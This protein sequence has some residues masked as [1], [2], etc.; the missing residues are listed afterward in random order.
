MKTKFLLAFFLAGAAISAASANTLVYDPYNVSGPG[1]YT[2]GTSLSNPVNNNQPAAEGAWTGPV[3]GFTTYFVS[4]EGLTYSGLATSGGSLASTPLGTNTRAFSSTNITDTLYYSFLV[5]FTDF[6]NVV[7][8]GLGDSSGA[9]AS[10]L[11]VGAGGVTAARTTNNYSAD[12]TTFALGTTYLVVGK[13]SQSGAN[14]FTSLWINPTLGVGEPGVANS[15]AVGSVGPGAAQWYSFTTNGDI[16]YQFDE[17]RVG[18]TWDSVT[19]AAIPEPST[20]LLIAGALVVG[21]TLRHK[22][23]RN[24]SKA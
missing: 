23:G 7:L 22:K 10:G 18:T 6:D 2:A 5:R 3:S 11:R 1:S 17:F 14:S 24:T 8:L 21:A 19:P 16:S 20:G 4:S 9:I 13:F 12:G 15:V